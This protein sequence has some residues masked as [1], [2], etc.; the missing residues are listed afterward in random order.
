LEYKL[1]ENVDYHKC[2]LSRKSRMFGKGA[3]L[4]SDQ[5]EYIELPTFN[6]CGRAFDG[7]TVVVEVLCGSLIGLFHQKKYLKEWKRAMRDIHPCTFDLG[8][9]VRVGAKLRC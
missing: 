4:E 2:R 6:A 3:L 5:D 1:V 9:T 8:F 7:D